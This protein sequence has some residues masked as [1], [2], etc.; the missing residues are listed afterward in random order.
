MRGAGQGS[1]LRR[2]MRIVHVYNWLD[3]KVGGPPPVIAGLAGGQQ[4][5]G[6]EVV[7][8]SSDPPGAPDVERFLAERLDPVPRRVSVDPGAFALPLALGKAA[9]D[10]APVIR[11]A[12]V[13]HL[14]GLWAPVGLVAGQVCRRLGVSYVLTAHGMLHQAALDQKWLKKRV[15]LFALG[16]AGLLSHASALHILNEEERRWP[17]YL[18]PPRRV[19]VIPNGVFPEEFQTL[20]AR[21][22]FRGQ[23]PGL[24]EAPFVLY[25]AR[26]HLQKGTDLLAE[27][28]GVLARARP[29]V[30]LVVAGPDQGA[31]ADFEARIR[32]HGVQDRVHVVGPRY[33]RARIEAMCD[34]DVF[35]LPSR[36]EGFS[37]GITE[38]LACGVPV[39]V[40]KTCNFPL[41]TTERLGRETSLDAASLAEGLQAVLAEPSAAREMGARGRA[42]VLAR[43]T[44]PRIAAEMVE[45][46]RECVGR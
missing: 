24:G 30:H 37:M 12:D 3:P 18:R 15:G 43:F 44:W 36:Q 6:H 38:A 41:V 21:G 39:V 28:F 23:V 32:R 45:L 1:K 26:L 22:T 46:Y 20:P 29:E 8:V 27:A 2:S 7:L 9:R 31:R 5:L 11:A 35:C 17:W 4:G 42:L 40:T 10:L 25:L 33:G 16:H 34:A 19:A 14:H 13:V